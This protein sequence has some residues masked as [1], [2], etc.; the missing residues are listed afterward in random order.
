MNL[1]TLV[2]GAELAQRQ[3]RGNVLVAD[4]RFDLAD[5]GKGEREHAQAH[6]PGAVYFH[7]DRDLSDLGKRGLGR[8]PLP[9]DLVFSAALARAGWRPGVD[10]VVYDDAQG[11]LAG[12]RM[13][14]LLRLA[15]VRNAAV[16]DGGW[17]AWRDAGL[18]VESG[19]ATPAETA[20]QL[21]LDRAQVVWFDELER[22]RA[23][24]DVLLID[25][26]AAARYRGE[27]EPIDAVAGHVPDA[28]NRPF[29]DNLERDG[30][31]KPREHLRREFEQLLGTRPA[32]DVVHMCGSGVTACHNLLAMEHAGLA[33][34][35]VFAPSW[36]G[37]ISDASRPVAMGS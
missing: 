23:S 27:V 3:A 37:W 16:L 11:A 9:H 21:N 36:S 7:L 25:A 18:P 10:V 20:V 30:R 24:G 34:S 5:A 2:T 31:F 1:A 22:R 8:H 12:A 17:A 6:I 14:W 29:A 13:W 19:V 28:R 26:R 15:G 32:R 4:C 35:R 33:G